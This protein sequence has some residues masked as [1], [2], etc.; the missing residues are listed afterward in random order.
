MLKKFDQRRLDIHN[1][2][3]HHNLNYST[4]S[5]QRPAALPHAA[6]QGETIQSKQIVLKV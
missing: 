5:V 3:N 6:R 2:H 1:H 4:A